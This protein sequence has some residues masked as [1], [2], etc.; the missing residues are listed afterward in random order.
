MRPTPVSFWE[1][2]TEL[3]HIGHTNLFRLTA[4]SPPDDS[5]AMTRTTATLE[6]E[7]DVSPRPGPAWAVAALVLVAAL[8]CNRAKK[9]YPTISSRNPDGGSVGVTGT[10]KLIRAV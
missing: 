3:F 8:G 7:M 10:S 1:P 6:R 4:A 5:I 9:T 2:V